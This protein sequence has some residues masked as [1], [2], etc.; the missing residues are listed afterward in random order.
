MDSIRF[1]DEQHAIVNDGYAH[2]S[3]TIDHE[4]EAL[5]LTRTDTS[6]ST[7]SGDQFTRTMTYYVGEIKPVVYSEYLVSST[8]G[9][10][11][12]G[13]TSTGK[14][15]LQESNGQLVAPEIFFVYHTTNYYQG[16]TNNILQ[17]DFFK[18]MAEGDTASIMG[19]QLLY[20]KQ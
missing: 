16:N 19:Y 3:C 6:Q 1:V 18:N 9:Y 8:R 5:I 15:V 14:Y 12:F 20:E 13:Y 10:Y 7:C 11:V 4:N 2:R 17:D